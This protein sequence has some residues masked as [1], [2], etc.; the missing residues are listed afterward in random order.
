[1]FEACT[2][3]EA[4]HEA[5]IETRKADTCKIA[6]AK[7]FD[8][9][10]TGDHLTAICD[11]GETEITGDT[12]EIREA[13]RGIGA[14]WNGRAWIAEGNM[15]ANVR[16]AD[17]HWA[18]GR[19]T[20]A[21]RVAYWLSRPEPRFASCADWYDSNCTVREIADTT[22]TSANLAEMLR[23]SGASVTSL[24]EAVERDEIAVSEYAGDELIVYRAAR[25]QAAYDAASDLTTI[26]GTGASEIAQ[27]IEAKLCAGHAGDTWYAAGNHVI[28]VR[29]MDRLWFAA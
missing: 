28:D 5:I 6:F 3:N 2:N 10:Y 25:L 20:R 27:I 1:M 12:Y 24:A 19:T 7:I 18:G 26:T 14:R 9:A 15:V 22:D 11:A 29:H 13:M 23:E 4:A 8:S 17:H 21:K 16:A